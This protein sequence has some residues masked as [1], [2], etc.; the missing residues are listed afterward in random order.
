VEVNEAIADPVVLCMKCQCALDGTER[1]CGNCGQEVDLT[2]DPEVLDVASIKPSLTYF[3]VTLLVLASYKLTGIFPEGFEG[4]VL[5][6]AIDLAVLLVF[7]YHFRKEITPLFSFAG[8]NIK[9]VAL[10][11]SASFVAAIVVSYLCDFLNVSIFEEV[12]YGPYQFADTEN[13]L[14]WTI[15]LTC[16]FPAITEE[17][18]FR[19]F[20]FTNIAR[21]TSANTAMYVSSFIFG[22]LH[23]SYISMLWLIPIGIVFS[24]LRIRFNILWYGIIGHFA[25]NLFISLIDF[26]FIPIGLF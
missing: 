3:F 18:A 12:Y 10:T 4:S 20:L 22:V 5:V 2:S 21:I 14:L 8:F 25:Y 19:G 23:L 15:V 9:V 7:W 6:S 17:V 13:P 26:G 24:F 11:I 16:I 1:F